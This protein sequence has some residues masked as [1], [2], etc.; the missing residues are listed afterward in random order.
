MPIVTLHE[1]KIYVLTDFVNESANSS[2]CQLFLATPSFTQPCLSQSDT[3]HQYD[4]SSND[5]L[6]SL[7]RILHFDCHNLSLQVVVPTQYSNTISITILLT[8]LHEWLS[9][10][11]LL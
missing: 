8:F 7:P 1:K 6:G 11:Q 3:E 10:V 5:K 9:C 4:L 2:K